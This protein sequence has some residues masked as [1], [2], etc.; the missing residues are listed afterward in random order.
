MR[1]LVLRVRI[2]TAFSPSCSYTNPANACDIFPEND[3]SSTASAEYIG[4]Q[5]KCSNIKNQLSTREEA[6]G[7]VFLD[8]QDTYGECCFDQCHLCEEDEGTD[9]ELTVYLNGKT[10]TCN[11]VDNAFFGKSVM[12][13]SEECS[14]VKEEHAATC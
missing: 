9:F 14:A 7:Q 3:V 12:A 6:E 4:K 11:E 1:R 2:A 10:T 13:S 8:A 5:T